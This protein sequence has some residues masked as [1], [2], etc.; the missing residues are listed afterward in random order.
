MGFTWVFSNDT[1][2]A[3]STG[4]FFLF[5]A[6]KVESDGTRISVSTAAVSSQTKLSR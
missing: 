3:K 5:D 4:E 1:S 6:D 2:S